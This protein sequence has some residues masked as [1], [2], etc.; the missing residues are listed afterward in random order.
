MEALRQALEQGAEV[1]DAL[2][3]AAAAA[4][5]GRNATVPLAARKG[6][7]SSPGERSAGH[8]DPG[9]SSAHLLVQT[10]AE[11]LG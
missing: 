7:A 11:R 2:R 8:Q 3:Q 5:Q 10:A 1:G 4:E 6:R 9:A